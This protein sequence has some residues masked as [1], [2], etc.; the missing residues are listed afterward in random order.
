[1]KYATTLDLQ[2]FH[3]E[4]ILNHV[5]TWKV[6]NSSLYA[7]SH[8]FP[9]H[10]SKVFKEYN[11]VLIS[12]IKLVQTNTSRVLNKDATYKELEKRIQ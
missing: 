10:S 4:G 2:L 6:L 1:M 5:I 8:T 9:A 3:F 7:T 12:L 11:S